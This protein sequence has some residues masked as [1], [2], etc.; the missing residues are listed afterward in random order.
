MAVVF[1]VRR[2]SAFKFSR[3]GRSR[4]EL[5]YRSNVCSEATAG[6]VI[7]RNLVGNLFLP[8]KIEVRRL[9]S[10][11][12]TS[13]SFLRGEPFSERLGVRKMGCCTGVRFD[14]CKR[15]NLVSLP[16]FTSPHQRRFPPALLRE[17]R[18]ALPQ[19]SLPRLTSAYIFY[20]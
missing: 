16:V 11:L 8:L 4:V 13:R 3:W 7:I 10:K 9:S 18:L 15:L 2:A 5:I 20:V 6:S 14:K 19:F 1:G 12:M 17:R